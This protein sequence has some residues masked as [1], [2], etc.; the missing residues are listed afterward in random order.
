MLNLVVKELQVLWSM[1]LLVIAVSDAARALP[2]IKYGAKRARPYLKQMRYVVS[3]N[4]V[5]E[6][7]N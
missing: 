3:N 4:A 6:V 2:A 7:I 1:S 5:V